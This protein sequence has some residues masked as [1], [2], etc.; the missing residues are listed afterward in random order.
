VSKD[1]EPETGWRLTSTPSPHLF[2]NESSSQSRTLSNYSCPGKFQSIIE[3]GY[4]VSNQSATETAELADFIMSYIDYF[5]V[6]KADDI[7]VVYN[8]ASCGLNE[9][10]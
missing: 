2:T 6:P 5:G 8:G 1:E 3:R 9:T 10:V 4:V 7:R